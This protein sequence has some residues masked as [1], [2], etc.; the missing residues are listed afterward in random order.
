MKNTNLV[1][2][3]IL[4]FGSAGIFMFSFGEDFKFPA[5][6]A[7]VIFGTIAIGCFRIHSQKETLGQNLLSTE[8]QNSGITENKNDPRLGK[9]EDLEPRD[10]HEVYLVLSKEERESG[11]L[12]P[13]YNNYVHKTCG[14][15]TGIAR[16]I[17]ETFARDPKFYTHTYCTHC[18]KHLPVAEFTW[19]GTSV[20]VGN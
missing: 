4:A 19:G 3:F 10:Q 7:A 11:F 6:V 15:E 2:G 16:E 13:V 12:R 5:L 8:N 14:H 20:I 9:S 1:L 18:R 17:A